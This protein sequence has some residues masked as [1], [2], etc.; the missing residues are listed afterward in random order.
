MDMATQQRIDEI[1]AEPED[2]SSDKSEV[3]ELVDG[4]SA[5]MLAT[6]TALDIVG[7]T[8]TEAFTVEEWVAYYEAL[9]PGLVELTVSKRR[10]EAGWYGCDN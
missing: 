6:I 10:W 8:D 3:A 1:L 7:H 4:L 2:H 5:Q 9:V